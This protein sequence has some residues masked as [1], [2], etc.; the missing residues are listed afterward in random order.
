MFSSVKNRELQQQIINHINHYEMGKLLRQ[1][2]PVVRKLSVH[3]VDHCNLGCA[4]CSHFCPLAA[5]GKNAFI[6]APAD[7]ERDLARFA[8]LVGPRVQVMEL[9]GGEP[10]LHPDVPAIL[11]IARRHFPDSVIKFITNGIL[12]PAQPESFWI[13][14]RK[15]A[16][17]LEPTKY[18]VSVDWESVRKIAARYGVFFRFFANTDA[19]CKTMYHKPL[20][21]SGLQDPRLSFHFCSHGN[22]GCAQLYHGKLYMCPIVAYIKYFNDHFGKNLKVLPEDWLDIYAPIAAKDVFEFLSRPIPFCRY[23][24]TGRCTVGHPWR[25]SEKNIKEWSL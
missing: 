14:M 15:N 9:Y 4:N 13:A 23:C 18:P 6:L 21:F 3:L 19:V 17:C 16:I 12:L 25:R 2:V 7:F 10:L 20:D 22:G 24:D 8:E 11:E 5:A 1:P